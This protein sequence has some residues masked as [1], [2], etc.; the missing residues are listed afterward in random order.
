MFNPEEHEESSRKQ[1][2][3]GISL[4]CSCESSILHLAG[5]IDLGC[6]AELKAALVQAL[7][8]SRQITVSAAALTSVDV[9]AVQLLWAAQ[10]AAGQRGMGFAVSAAPVETVERQ[11]AELGMSELKILA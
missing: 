4:S 9:T 10:R 7:D 6:A 5:A 1:P 8:C 2:A 11:L 3:V